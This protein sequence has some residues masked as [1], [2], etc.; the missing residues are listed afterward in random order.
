LGLPLKFTPV[1]TWVDLIFRI[2]ENKKRFG[3]EVIYFGDLEQFLNHPFVQS[4]S[5]KNE[6]KQM[7]ELEQNSKKYNRIVQR[8]DNLEL[9]DRILSILKILSANW[10]EQWLMGIKNIRK[11]NQIIFDTLSEN[12]LFERAVVQHFDSSL[13]E[14]ENIAQEGLPPMNIKSFGLLFKNHAFFRVST[15]F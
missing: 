3:E 7:S 6:Q 13:I 14:I 10:N 2:Q 12:H 9:S 8:I 11:A 15:L 5:D 1:K 4:G